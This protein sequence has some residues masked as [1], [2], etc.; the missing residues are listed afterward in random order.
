MTT[1]PHVR[2]LARYKAWADD[3]IYDAAAR[4]PAGE[5]EKPRKSVFRNLVH[6][7]NHV[8]VIDRVF[9][10]HLE[11][12]G[13]GYTARNT[14]TYPPLAE[15][16]RLQREM[17]RWYLDWADAQ[18][19]ATLGER[20]DFEYIGGGSGSMTR[21][22]ILLHVVNHATYHR[23]FVAD[24]FYQVPVRPPATDFTVFVRDARPDLE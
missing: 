23:G 5:A 9:Q 3:L 16:A 4:L 13:H 12:R 15:L 20:V 18:T 8:Y 6:M 24:F 22:E 10:C 14:E 21:G 19:E 2:L 7:L 11:G 17:D 1:L